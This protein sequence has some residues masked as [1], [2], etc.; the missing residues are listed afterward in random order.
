[1]IVRALSMSG[2]RVGFIGLGNMGKPMA[3]RLASEKFI[4]TV[5]DIV[6]EAIEE[7]EL[8]GA[9]A[10]KSCREVAVASDVIFSMV[11]DIPQTDEVMFGKDGVWEGI[12]EG[13]TIVITS[14]IGPTYC[15]ELYE[16]ARERGVH[17][18]DCG[19]SDPSG[20]RHDPGVLSLMIGGDEDEVKRYW[21][22]FKAMGDI[23]FYLGKIGSGQSY[24]LVNNMAAKHIGTVER[25]C[26]I[27]CLNLGLKVGLDL[28]QM[29][30]VMSVSAGA[31]LFQNMGLKKGLDKKQILEILRIPTPRVSESG[32]SIKDELYYGMEM[33]DAAGVEMPICRL[34]DGLDINSV[35]S[36][37]S[38]LRKNILPDKG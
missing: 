15:Q 32:F 27:E 25:L 22:V 26:L 6:K 24:K 35:Y 20:F 16:K 37:F 30:D 10:A 13:K 31:R 23:I 14:S 4:L 21:P 38:S 7:L 29:I 33:A 3:K 9:K 8:V 18:I 1:M 28:Q 12:S 36:E 11:R 19:V 2:I 34:I 17:V 5:Y